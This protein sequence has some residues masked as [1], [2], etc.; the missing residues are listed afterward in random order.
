MYG[1]VTIA[2]DVTLTAPT[3]FAAPTGGTLR[4]HV[5]ESEMWVVLEFLGTYAHSAGAVTFGTF[6]VDGADI[7]A[8]TDGLH[9]NTLGTDPVPVYFNKRLRLAQGEH[10]LEVRF[11][12]ASGNVVVHGA[13]V[14]CVLSALRLSHNATVAANQNSKQS[15]G[16][17]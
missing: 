17:Y 13:G 7:G 4:F 8:L 11:K 6:Y 1:E 10:R 15:G 3:A 14:P 12:S 16:I 5:E 9:E 2:A